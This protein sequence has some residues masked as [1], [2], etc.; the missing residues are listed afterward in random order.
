MKSTMKNMVLSLTIITASMGAI[1]AG[2]HQLTEE[3]IAEAELKAKTEALQ[4]VLPQLDNDPL[5][6]AKEITVT[7][8]TRPVTVYT[9]TKDGDVSGYAVESWTMDG[10]S[11]EIRV[12]V[13]FDNSGVITGY[14]VLQHAETPGLGAKANDWFRDPTGSRSIIGSDTPLKVSKDGGQIDGITAATITS[15]AFLDAVNRARL[16]IE[17]N[18]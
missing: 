18:K 4:Q 15:R 9:A 2:V 16:A 14:Q 5:S 8:D 1:L 12:M 13:G 6:T 11:G 7:A 17:Q 10:F 3:P